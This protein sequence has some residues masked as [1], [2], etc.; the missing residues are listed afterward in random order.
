[1]YFIT[2][3]V[4]K[5]AWHMTWVI[6]H[7]AGLKSKALSTQLFHLDIFTNISFSLFLPDVPTPV[8]PQLFSPLNLRLTTGLRQKP[9]GGSVAGCHDSSE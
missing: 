4:G 5:L 1:M 2:T 8:T 7:V 9:L 6:I 3:S